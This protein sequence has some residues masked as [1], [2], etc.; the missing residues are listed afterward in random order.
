MISKKLKLRK[1]QFLVDRFVHNFNELEKSFFAHPLKFGLRRQA[2]FNFVLKSFILEV[3]AKL[4]RAYP[5][6]HKR[7]E[8]KF[9]TFKIIESYV[10]RR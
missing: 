7:K 2:H 5:P 1:G 9:N 3:K 10:L 6:P 4:K 8:L